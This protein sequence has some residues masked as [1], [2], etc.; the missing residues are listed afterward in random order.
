MIIL[1]EDDDTVDKSVVGPLLVE[2]VTLLPMVH[3]QHASHGQG[4]EHHADCKTKG[5]LQ[6]WEKIS[7]P[8]FIRNKNKLFTC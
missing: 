7:Q 1:T 6:Y 5:N 2:G 3:T 4:T 8:L